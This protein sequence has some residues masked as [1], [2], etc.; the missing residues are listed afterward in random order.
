MVIRV[1]GEPVKEEEKTKHDVEV[2]KEVFEKLEA[3]IEE[4]K[5]LDIKNGAFR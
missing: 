2:S 4:E 1:A 3:L 5:C